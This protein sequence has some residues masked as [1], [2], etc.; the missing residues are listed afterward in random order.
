MINKILKSIKDNLP[1]L[2]FIIVAGLLVFPIW[3]HL[4][5]AS[6]IKDQELTIQGQTDLIGRLQISGG[7]QLLGGIT[8]TK[9]GVQTA[10]VT[11]LVPSASFTVNLGSAALPVNKIFTTTASA[12][13]GEF[14]TNASASKYF[15]ATLATCGDGSHAL[16]WTGGLFGCQALTSSGIVAQGG[17]AA[18]QVMFF[19]DAGTTASGSTKFTWNNTT[20]LLRITGSASTSLNFEAGGYASASKYFGGSL[21]TC[22]NALTWTAGSFGCSAAYLTLTGGTLSGDLFGT[23]VSLSKNFEVLGYASVSGKFTQGSVASNSFLGSLSGPTTGTLSVG[24][25]NNPL[26][27]LWSNII[28]SV[29]QFFFPTTTS[30]VPAIAGEA[31]VNTASGSLEVYTGAAN[32]ILDGKICKTFVVDAPTAANPGFVGP[33]YFDDPFTLISVGMI[34]TGSNAAGWNLKYGAP[35]TITTSVFTLNKSASTSSSPVYTSFANSALTDKQ[36]LEVVITSRS[37][38]LQSFSVTACGRATH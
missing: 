30:T 2:P 8:R 17:V 25:S 9:I 21:A 37:A 7:E 24:T 14:S 16:N 11:S 26:K 31:I 10:W 36:G 5:L 13:L 34:A 3:S 12:S 1:L 4:K 35:A 32:K 33:V 29:V 23:N 19:Q 22:A 6:Q 18:N 38:V 20:T 15:G 28:K 27:I